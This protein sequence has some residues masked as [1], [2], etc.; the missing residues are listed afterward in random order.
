MARNAADSVHL[1][2][3]EKDQAK[4]Q[5]EIEA[6]DKANESRRLL[7]LG[8]AKRSDPEH[9]A[10]LEADA[11][12]VEARVV[13]SAPRVAEG[14]SDTPSPGVSRPGRSPSGLRRS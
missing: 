1:E 3:T 14:S 8:F 2:R 6:G 5:R 11:A 10:V 13:E 4:Q 12:L 9:A 7:S